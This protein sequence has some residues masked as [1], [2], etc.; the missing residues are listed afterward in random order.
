MNNI[1]G[2]ILGLTSAV[3]FGLEPTDPTHHDL[4]G[5]V[6][7]CRK[8]RDLTRNL[9]GFARR[10]R[11]RKERIAL[12]GQVRELR[13]L[14]E[15]TIPKQVA[16]ETELAANLAEIEGDPSQVHQALLNLCLNAVDA[17]PRGGTL[18]IT[19]SNR[20]RQLS[21]RSRSPE[22]P[23]GRYVTVCVLD[24]GIGMDH[25]TQQRAFEPFFTTKP[26]GRGTGLGLSMVYGTI[27]S[28]GGRV[29]LESEPGRGTAV[30]I[31]LPALAPLGEGPL[32]R[33]E[34]GRPR[35]ATGLVLVVDDEPL[36]REATRRMLES[37]GYGVILAAG[38]AEALA[39][40]R[41]RRGEI[42]LVL[43]DLLMPGMDGGET[44]SELRAL[45][46]GLSVLLCSGYGQERQ[47]DALL[48]RGARGFIQKPF[49]IDEL[50]RVLVLA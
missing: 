38:G 37:L 43:L 45:D 20:D 15:R 44:F 29:T 50:S 26:K 9:L 48:A 11:Y 12:N 6:E 24:T 4:A 5:V 19:T 30:T 49:D 23:P 1:L 42:R 21:D 39:A 3:Q 10:G 8:G 41:S 34:E 13:R 22:L 17:M 16:I 46:P 25:E 32:A 36:F 7:A 18:T 33:A 40:L 27:Q 31:D 35:P 2:T 28:H 14:L 47:A